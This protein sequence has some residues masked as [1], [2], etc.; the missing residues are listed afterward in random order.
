MDL[1]LLIYLFIFCHIET[2]LSGYLITFSGKKKKR[3]RSVEMQP[4]FT[5]EQE[6]KYTN[7]NKH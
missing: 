5:G 2:K 7:K 1:F 4:A 3:K 6:E